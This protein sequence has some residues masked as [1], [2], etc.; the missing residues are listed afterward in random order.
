MQFSDHSVFANLF[1]RVTECIVS[2]AIR[3][4]GIRFAASTFKVHVHSSSLPA[5]TLNLELR[6]AASGRG[7]QPGSG[8]VAAATGKGR[9]REE[10]GA[11]GMGGTSGMGA[12]RRVE[13]G[14]GWVGCE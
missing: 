10:G 4:V 8:R 12:G 5:F 9:T 2:F 6:S 13:E 11:S 14:G 7:E 3:L 1:R